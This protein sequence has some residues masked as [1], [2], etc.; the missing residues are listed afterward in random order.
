MDPFF[1]FFIDCLQNNETS[2][3]MFLENE[4]PKL[5]MSEICSLIQGGTN[6]VILSRLIEEAN[7]NFFI[8]AVFSN[9]KDVFTFLRNKYPD[10]NLKNI[11]RQLFFHAFVENENWEMTKM[12]EDCGFILF[13][14]L[15]PTFIM[16]DGG[17]KLRQYR[18]FILDI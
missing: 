11:I 4:K 7:P 2:A 9:R 14:N 18:G 17:E 5:N 16:S 6:I 3:L 10:F 8:T 13:E 12:L 1:D 15:A